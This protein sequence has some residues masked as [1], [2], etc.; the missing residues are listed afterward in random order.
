[1]LALHHVEACFLIG[2]KTCIPQNVWST[3]CNFGANIWGISSE[4]PDVW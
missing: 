3:I 4:D 2:L 1:M